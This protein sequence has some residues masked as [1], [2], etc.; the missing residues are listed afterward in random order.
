[1][2]DS[3]ITESESAFQQAKIR[4]EEAKALLQSGRFADAETTVESVLHQHPDYA[5]ALYVLAVAHR[6]QKNFDQAL[7]ALEHLKK[8]RPA[9]GRAFQEEGHIHLSKRNRSAAQ[10]AFAHAVQLNTSLFASWE[11]LHRLY[12]ESGQQPQAN[13]AKT[14]FAKLKALPPALLGVRNMIEEGK[15]FQAEQVCRQFMQTNPR[16]VEGMRLLADLGVKSGVLDDAEVLLENAIAFEPNNNL[17]RH[18]YM[19]VLY[20][21]QKYAQAL[22]QAT[23][24]RDKEPDNL[25]YRIS[26]ANQ[27]VAVGDFP[28]AL[29]IYKNAITKV[30]NRAD[31]HLV[32]GHALKTIGETDKAIA[33]YARAYKARSNFGDAYWSLAN[34]KTYRFTDEQVSNMHSEE[35]APSTPVVDRIHF[36]FALGKYYEDSGDFETSMQFYERGNE[37]ERGANNY[38]MKKMSERLQLQI[39]YCTAELFEKKKDFG[40]DAPDPIF[41]LGLPRA[42]STLLEQILASHSQIDGT[43]ELPNISSLAFDLAGRRHTYEELQYPKNLHD[44]SAEQL[45]QYGKAF[46]D[47]TRV[48]RDEA[49]FFIDKMPNNFRHIALIHLILPNAKIIDARRHPMA[50]CFSGFKQLFANGQEFTYGQTEIGTY[51][52]DY[53]ELMDHWDKVI[54]GKILRVQYEDVVADTEAQVHRILDYLGL[55][56]EEACLDFHKTK[57]S[58]RTASS[59]QVRQPI[60]TSGLEQWRNF[61]PWLDPLKSS[62]GSVLERYP[63]DNP[64]T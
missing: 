37:L 17:A 39:E 14:Q 24:L 26:Y 11:A 29:E 45:Q 34:L 36:C 15:L 3:S 47:D 52:R 48:H 30:P 42:G 22:E 56:F 23:I 55:P 2:Q 5:E 31:L 44:L 57:R 7:S 27:C 49:P 32:H 38:E 19:H 35:Q 25:D 51:Y 40:H 28:P 16:H 63:I 18:E 41:I 59:E 12:V 20:R 21:R 58:V 64:T 33:A 46:I 6:Y 61:E 54:P 50:C 43:L 62:L 13:F 60:Y 4:V 53:V 1:M 8:V 10:D 9:Y